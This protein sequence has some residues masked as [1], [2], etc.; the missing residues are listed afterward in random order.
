MPGRSILDWYKMSY[1]SLGSLISWA[2]NELMNLLQ[3]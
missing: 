3:W 2:K 1:R